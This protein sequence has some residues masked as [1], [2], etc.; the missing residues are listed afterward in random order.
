[1]VANALTCRTGLVYLYSSQNIE[2]IRG[3]NVANR[4]Y[5][6]VNCT[7]RTRDRAASASSTGRRVKS[8]LSLVDATRTVLNWNSFEILSFSLS[9][10]PSR[11]LLP[12]GHVQSLCFYLRSTSSF[13]RSLS[14][15]R[16]CRL[17]P[18]F[19]PSRFE[20]AKHD[21]SLAFAV[22]RDISQSCAKIKRVI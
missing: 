1:M 2:N 12:P 22:F 18:S 11:F 13:T 20:R 17:P 16:I 10:F 7:S 3:A 9:R 4:A 8:S 5:R 6:K 14:S 15:F 21:G 19:A